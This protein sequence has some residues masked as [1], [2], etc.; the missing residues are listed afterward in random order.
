MCYEQYERF[1]FVYLQNIIKLLRPTFN[2]IKNR[3]KLAYYLRR[4]Y[5]IKYAENLD[6]CKGNVGLFDSLITFWGNFAL[7]SNRLLK[8]HK[9]RRFENTRQ[10]C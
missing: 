1:L 3:P 8:L 9:T 6:L 7:Q 4:C 10:T 2:A 5:M